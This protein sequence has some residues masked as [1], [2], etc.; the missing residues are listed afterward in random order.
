MWTIDLSGGGGGATQLKR[1]SS[2]VRIGRDAENDVRLSGWRVSRRHAEVFVSNDRAF[3]RDL[4]SSGG[5]MVNGDRVTTHGPL[6]PTDRIE[7]GSYQLRVQW[8]KPPSAAHDPEATVGGAAR[9]VP[10]R[11][12][13]AASASTQAK[14]QPAPPRAQVSAGPAQ[15][16]AADEPAVL[17]PPPSDPT[18]QWRRVLHERLLEAFDVRRVDVHRM[19][20]AELRSRTESLIG[21]L[22]GRMPEI[23]AS[24]DRQTLTAAVRDEAI[25]LG[26]PVRH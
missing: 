12:P 23:P 26:R 5:T 25:G 11:A 13:A 14:S 10:A 9:S 22:I 1:E 15:A 2:K 7:V 19:S 24:I 6:L 8:L 21:E 16:A 3:V 17:A 4:D 18:F 20:D